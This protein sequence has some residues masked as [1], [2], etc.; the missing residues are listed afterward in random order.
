MEAPRIIQAEALGARVL[1]VSWTPVNSDSSNPINGYRI[2]VATASSLNGG[3]LV[4]F[5]EELSPNLTSFI[6]HGLSPYQ[7]RGIPGVTYNVSVLA[8]N[9][10]GNGPLSASHSVFT[11]CFLAASR[12]IDEEE[13]TVAA[14]RK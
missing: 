5:E 9:N 6:F 11:F 13:P 10:D 7:Y 1:R 12:I 14:T 2:V 3:G 8:F 4:T